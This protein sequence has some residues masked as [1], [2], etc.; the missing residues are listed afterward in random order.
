VT[1][2]IRLYELYP[3]GRSGLS[4][5]TSDYHGETYKVAAFSIRQAYWLV[6]NRQWADGPDRPIGIVEH[7]TKNGPAE[8]WH[9][10]W[11]GCRI[12]WGLGLGHAASK[13]AITRAM[14]DHI[15]NA[16][17]ADGGAS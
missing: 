4:T 9:R 3:G 10:L 12:H 8:G 11:D 16:H 13:T 15:E 7:Y 17:H 14:R 1:R 5:Q 2:R 6:G